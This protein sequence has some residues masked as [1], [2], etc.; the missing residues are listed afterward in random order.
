MAWWNDPLIFPKLI[1][2]AV[3]DTVATAAK[4]APGVDPLFRERRV[5]NTND[6]RPR[7]EGREETIVQ[8]Q[9]QIETDTFGLG[10][11]TTTGNSPSASMV[12]II[13]MS[14][15]RAL[16]LVNPSTG[17]PTLKV[18]D[19]LAAVRDL[20]GSLQQ[21]F[22]KPPKRVGL[23]ASEVKPIG[24]GYGSGGANYVQMSFGDRPVGKPEG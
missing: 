4:V 20:D 7:D 14:D 15:L 21:D 12:L 13:R 11:L 5:T 17:E 10:R 18:G 3:Y 6:G 19:R 22:P 16:N 1:D 2:I 23:Y 9:A 8:V 24:F